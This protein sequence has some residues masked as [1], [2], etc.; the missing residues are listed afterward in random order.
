MEYYLKKNLIFAQY[1]NEFKYSNKFEYSFFHLL[2]SSQNFLV[3]YSFCPIPNG[4]SSED[5]N[6]GDTKRKMYLL[7][8]YL[9]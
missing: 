2:H 7:H 6:L 1:L 9:P 3:A 5:F 4:K 8:C